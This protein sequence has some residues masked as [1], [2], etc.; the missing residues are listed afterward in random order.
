M[1]GIKYGKKGNKEFISEENF[2]SLAPS[3]LKKNHEKL[4]RGYVCLE[5]LYDTTFN[6]KGVKSNPNRYLWYQNDN[7]L[8][9]VKTSSL[10]DIQHFMFFWRLQNSLEKLR[11]YVS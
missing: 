11:H 1:K 2:S 7:S 6:M 3:K 9:R 10:H 8:E 5:E 4:S